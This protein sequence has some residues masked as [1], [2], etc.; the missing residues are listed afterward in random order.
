MKF[1]A[2]IALLATAVAAAPSERLFSL[3]TSGASNSSHND[4]YLS[5]G[6]GIINDPLN[7]EAVF[8]GATADRAAVF[9][10]ANGSIILDVK[11]RGSNEPWRLDLINVEGVRKERAQISIKPTHGSRGFSNSPEGIKG[12]SETWDGWLWCPT[13]V[14][15]GQFFPNLHFLSKSVQEPAV[16]EGC[17][18]IELHAVPAKSA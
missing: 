2:T 12:P 5:V 10:F 17:D 6:R 14:E 8:A 1:F 7:N 15:A 13:N 3:K 16:P 9:T 18:K 11:T 4:L